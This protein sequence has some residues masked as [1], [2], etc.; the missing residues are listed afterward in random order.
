MPGERA[1]TF[2]GA[3]RTAAGEHFVQQ[4]SP[5]LASQ[6]QAASSADEINR[7]EIRAQCTGIRAQQFRSIV[8]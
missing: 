7:N 8:K 3:L 6:P 5:H 2:V 4:S 1:Q